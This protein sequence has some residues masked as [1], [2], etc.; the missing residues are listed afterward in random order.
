MKRSKGFR[1]KTR[2]KLQRTKRVGRTNPITRKIQSFEVNDLV[3]IIIDPSI[4]RGQPHPRFH[5]KTGRIVDKMGKSYVVTIK[6][7]K[8]DKKLIV[9]PEHLQLQE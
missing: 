8:K 7:G 4:H 5:G 9:R 3:H 1:S 6:D 2:H